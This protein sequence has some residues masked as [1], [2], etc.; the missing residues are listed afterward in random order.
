[1]SLS[2][3]EIEPRPEARFKLRLVDRIVRVLISVVLP[4]INIVTAQPAQDIGVHRLTN[5]S[6]KCQRSSKLP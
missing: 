2:G 3:T 6:S 1:M 4:P 5:N